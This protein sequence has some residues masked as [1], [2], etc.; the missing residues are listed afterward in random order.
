[1]IV[2]NL[3]TELFKEIYNEWFGGGEEKFEQSV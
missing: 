1:M 2:Q 3:K